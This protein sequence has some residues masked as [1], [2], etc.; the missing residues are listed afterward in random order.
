LYLAFHRPF[1]ILLSLAVLALSGLCLLAVMRLA[2]WSWN[3]LNLMALPLVLGTGVDY[4]IFMQLALKRHHGDVHQAYLSVGRA[5]LLCG[6][7]AIAGFG[8]LAWSSNAG[9]ASLGQVCAVGVGS[10]MLIAIFLLPIWWYWVTRNG[11]LESGSVAPRSPSGS[12]PPSK[13]SSLYS[14]FVWRLGLSLI[15]TMPVILTSA[16]ASVL[17]NM[18]RLLASHRRAVVMQ[19]LAP[20]LENDSIAIHETTKTL[21][22]RFARKV[23]DLWRYEAGMDISSL[24]GNATGWEHFKEAQSQRRGILLL[25]PHLGN[26]EFG[27][28]ML[29]QRGVSLQVLTLAEPGKDF[30][31]LR[32]ASR[33]RWNIETLVVGEDPLAFVEII[34]RLEAGATVALLVDR[35]PPASAITVELFGRPFCASIAAAELARASGCVL[36]PVYIPW[37]TNGYE[38]HMLPAIPYERAALRDRAARQ[39]LTQ[40]ILRTFEPIIRRYLDQWYHFVPVWPD[41][42]PDKKPPQ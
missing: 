14:S 30:T 15:K 11:S 41:S 26:W 27:G 18:Y 21:F 42:N 31:Q 10:N 36:L 4:S 35:P 8:S 20:A 40:Q 12:N 28:P 33:A 29:T 5:L 6:G 7:T 23:T 22:K 3:L 9:M 32:Q 2:G 34:K 16:L 25:T 38:A 39:K 17:A 37:E 19:N 1:E 24:L 13:P